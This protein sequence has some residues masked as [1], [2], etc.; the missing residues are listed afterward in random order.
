MSS[1]NTSNIS[2]TRPPPPQRRQSSIFTKEDVDAW[3]DKSPEALQSLVP[4]GNTEAFIARIDECVGK[5]PSIFTKENFESLKDVNALLNKVIKNRNQ[6]RA[7]N[8]IRLGINYLLAV[9][10]I[11]SSHSD[12]VAANGQVYSGNM[13]ILFVTVT[14]SGFG[15]MIGASAL[16]VVLLCFFLF[17]H[18]VAYPKHGCIT[19]LEVEEAYEMTNNYPAIDG[20]LELGFPARF[21]GKNW[22][23]AYIVLAISVLIILWGL[24]LYMLNAKHVSKT[25]STALVA[26]MTLLMQISTDFTEY[27]VYTRNQFKPCEYT[28]RTEGGMIRGIGDAA[29][30]DHEDAKVV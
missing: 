2:D 19:S 22:K 24:E 6:R 11:L 9:L 14:S 26:A 1:D 12:I 30:E 4:D 7:K 20:I 15:M 13:H 18:A 3:L 27:W 23:L 8:I 29:E 10:V 21:K 28:S 16:F 25:T 5:I 17:V